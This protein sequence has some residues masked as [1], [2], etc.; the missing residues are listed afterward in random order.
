MKVEVSND[1]IGDRIACAGKPGWSHA[2]LNSNPGKQ[3]GKGRRWPVDFLW[4]K[5]TTVM[6]LVFGQVPRL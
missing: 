1:G 6:G 4:R 2:A 3:T 5:A